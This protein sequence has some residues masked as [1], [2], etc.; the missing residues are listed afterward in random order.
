MDFQQ[1]VILHYL[2]VVDRLA[3]RLV[4]RSLRD[5]LQANGLYLLQQRPGHF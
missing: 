5:H 4:S 3:P 2:A 1:A